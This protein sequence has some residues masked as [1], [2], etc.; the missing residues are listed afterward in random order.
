MRE[1][2]VQ[3]LPKPDFSNFGRP[4]LQD[5][6]LKMPPKPVKRARAGSVIS[7]FQKQ[8]EA[9]Q[10]NTFK[11]K[12]TYLGKGSYSIAWTLEGN[13]DPIVPGVDNSDLVL[14]A[15]HGETSG[16]GEKKLRTYLRNEIE[17][18]RAAKAARL[19]VAEIYNADT[20][21][22]DG[23]II[24]RKVKGKVD[25]LNADQRLQVSRFFDA[26]FK[27]R[28]RMDIQLQNFCFENGQV[29]LID[30]IEDRED[31]EEDIEIDLFNKKVIEESW[32]RAYQKADITKDQA[33][34]FLN[35][36]SANHYPEFIKEKLGQFA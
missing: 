33:A 14:K 24:Q 23:Y 36:L 26:S 10:A 30:F 2:Q 11:Y 9:L 27:K 34:D 16:F 19:P 1:T 8:H 25:P 35:E 5:T 12:V 18:Y 17:N 29:I 7:V 31:D 13:E 32:I 22:Q 6:E 4:Q 3:S 20:A 21:E 28:I 15:F